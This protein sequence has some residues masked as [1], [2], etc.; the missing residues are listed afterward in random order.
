MTTIVGIKT[1]Y[2]PEEGIVM[3]S[4]TQLSYTD[5]DGQAWKGRIQKII[6]GQS[7]MLGHAGVVDRNLYDFQR[8]FLGQRKGSSEE[9]TL[10]LINQA[11]VNHNKGVRYKQT[12]FPIFNDLNALALREGIP[13][14][15]LHIFLL[16]INSPKLNLWEIDEFG[17]L[18]KSPRIREF[19]Y[20]AIGSGSDNA[21]KYIDQTVMRAKVDASKIN[22][23]QAIDLVVTSLH[24]AAEDLNTGDGIDVVIMTYSKITSYGKRIRNALSKAEKDVIDKIKSEFP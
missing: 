9:I 11:M 18:K 21:L 17:N 22:I 8:T 4:D 5:G 20:L 23:P 16:A 2:G 19:E 24:R 13:I 10:Q 3:G 7:V 6:Y 15:D 14:L 12:H 1:N